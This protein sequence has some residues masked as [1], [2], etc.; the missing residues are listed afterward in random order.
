MQ[1]SAWALGC[2]SSWWD[3]F[4]PRFQGEHVQLVACRPQGAAHTSQCLAL[5]NR[6]NIQ[7][8]DRQWHTWEGARTI[9][10][11]DLGSSPAIPPAGEAVMPLSLLSINT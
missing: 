3:T 8:P 10:H 9:M 6:R 4:P 2:R 11:R 7:A 1:G 5:Q